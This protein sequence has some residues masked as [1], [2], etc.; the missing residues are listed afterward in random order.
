MSNKTTSPTEPGLFGLENSSR[1]GKQHFSKN[2]FNSSFPVA[3]ALYMAKEGKGAVCLKVNKAGLTEG[4]ETPWEEIL[5][6]ESIEHGELFW[7]FEKK[8][9]EYEKMAFAGLPGVDVVLKKLNSSRE[10]KDAE[11]VRPFEIKLTVLPDNRTHARDDHLWGS[12]IVVR[13]QTIKYCAISIAAN[14]TELF[15]AIS[16]ILNPICQRIKNWE[17]ENDVIPQVQNFCDAL[18]QVMSMSNAKQTPLLLNPIWR[19]VGDSSMLAEEAFDFFVWNDFAIAMLAVGQSGKIT[20][21]IS[22]PQRAVLQLARSLNELTTG[23][24]F[25][26]NAAFDSMSY[27]QQ[28]DK[29][30]SVSGLVT[31][32]CY[33]D[34]YVSSPRIPKSALTKIVLNGG[35]KCLKPERRFDATIFF[36]T[37]GLFDEI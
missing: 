20:K 7:D 10:L 4:V 11:S 29:S 5:G 28:S 1:K 19:T 8:F 6:I 15:S 37:A 12:E 33:P 34:K 36:Q 13:P 14:N 32:E 9:Q 18:K 25:N 16:K 26:I 31:N 21:R 23:R 22:R 27:S 17:S 30:F 24:P 3:L 2:C 35:H